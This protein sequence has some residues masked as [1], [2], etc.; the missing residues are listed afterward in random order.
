MKLND[1]PALMR[2]LALRLLTT[3]AFIL[4]T[5][6][7]LAEDAGPQ[8][9]AGPLVPTLT[10][11]HK[12]GPFAVIP[13]V[14]YTGAASNKPYRKDN[15]DTW[16]PALDSIM[17]SGKIVKAG[18]GYDGAGSAKDGFADVTYR[19]TK[20][21]V[22]AVG[23]YEDVGQLSVPSE[24]DKQR[25]GYKRKSG[26]FVYGLFPKAGQALKIAVI[27]DRIDDHLTN[28]TRSSTES[29]VPLVRGD[30]QDPIKTERS[31]GKAVYE[32]KAPLNGID[33][34]KLEATF[35]ETEREANNFT[36]RESTPVANYNIGQKDVTRIGG[37]GTVEFAAF[38]A[39]N[40][41]RLGA[42]HTNY[43]G[44][45]LGGPQLN[46]LNIV[47][48]YQLPGIHYLSARLDGESAIDLTPDRHV[49][50][51]VRYE[52]VDTSASDLHKTTINAGST[53]LTSQQLYEQYYGANL[54]ND[55]Q[56]HN[57]S[58]KLDVKEEFLNDNMALTGS[59]GR[60]MRSGSQLEKY[61]AAPSRNINAAIG[62]PSRNVGNP[63]I[64]PE[65]HY[66]AEL[67]WSWK[68]DGYVEYG[69]SKPGGDSWQ[70][71]LSGSFDRVNNFITR[72]RAHGQDGIL[73]SDNATIWRN[74]DAD[75]AT[76]EFDAQWNATRNV[77]T[78]LNAAF[79]WGNNTSD[80]R[81]LYGVRPFE[82][83]WLVDYHDDL[84]NIGTW[85][86]GTKLRLVTR[87]SRVDDDPST[88]SGYDVGQT[89]GF[90]VLDL[91]GGA[92]IYNRV[93]VK[94]G[95]DNALDKRYSIHD[96]GAFTDAGA[97]DRVLAPGRTYYLRATASF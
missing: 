47:S 69:R 29:G 9:P 19:D 27:H 83:N 1:N 58:V 91:Y 22:K 84:T 30:G 59:V 14:D 50:L 78:R 74:V 24:T 95:I 75:L 67:G 39:K 94:L 71:Q 61:F 42:D 38:G 36:F 60:I 57:I 93:A 79:N 35:V 65:E 4:P 43:N 53:V 64:K 31:I 23:S 81:A 26:Q 55:S 49:N 13:I 6:N 96:I 82:V 76:A 86:A 16:S 8:L 15:I 17:S 89:G 25:Y 52:F 46:D 3:S 7:V 37:Q 44:K 77:S 97:P 10:Q 51:G 5:S 18:G 87:Q 20:H 41:V 88:G 63:Q 92:Q 90:G 12:P 33:A 21:L 66:K 85:H 28:S 70:V 54:D 34:I 62:T 80:N 48:A 2:G 40:R 68:G 32:I 56:D 73:L 72:D 45:R 11:H